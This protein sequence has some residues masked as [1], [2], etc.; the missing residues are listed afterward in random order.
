MRLTR[1]MVRDKLIRCDLLLRLTLREY[2][3]L[4]TTSSIYLVL[5][6][7]CSMGLSL[8]VRMRLSLGLSLG[9]LVLCDLLLLLLLMRMREVVVGRRHRACRWNGIDHGGGSEIWVVEGFSSRDTLGGIKLKKTFEEI[10]GLCIGFGQDISEGN[11]RITGK[12]FDSSLCTIARWL[13]QSRIRRMT[14]VTSY[15]A[16]TYRG[17]ARYLA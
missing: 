9:L 8:S 10:E 12:L 2:R 13:K 14:R 4:N 1:A 11:L 17:L 7:V 6:H 3:L 5:S 15:E 16:D